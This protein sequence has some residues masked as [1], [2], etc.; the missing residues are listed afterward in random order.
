MSISLYFIIK[1]VKIFWIRAYVDDNNKI[2]VGKLSNTSVMSPI[3]NV[4]LPTAGPEG[5]NGEGIT[6]DEVNLKI[7]WCTSNALHVGDIDLT[8]PTFITNHRTITGGDFSGIR[9]V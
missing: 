3:N 4:S 1:M 5:Q 8:N 2:Y 9:G 7:Y 6:I